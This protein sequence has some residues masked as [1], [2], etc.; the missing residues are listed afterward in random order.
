[1]KNIIILGI[2]DGHDCGAALIRNGKVIAA[3]QEERLSN[4][5]HHSGVPEISIRGVFKIAKIHPSE[6]N[7]IAIVSLNRVYSPL[8]EYPLKVKFFEKIAPLFHGKTFAK[9]Y[10]SILH[11]FRS[12]AFNEDISRIGN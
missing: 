7:A 8:E 11:K 6:V 1:M 10:V 2:N 5:K 4:I 9:L 12:I 3:V